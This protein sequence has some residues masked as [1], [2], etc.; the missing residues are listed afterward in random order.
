MSMNKK[1]L[2]F[3]ST[4]LLLLLCSFMVVDADTTLKH[5]YVGENFCAEESVQKVLV[6]AGYILILAKIAVPLILIIVGSLD[7]YKAVMG[8]DEKDLAK[9]LKSLVLRLIAGIFIFFVPTIVNYAFDLIYDSTDGEAVDK[10]CVTCVL[11]PGSC[12]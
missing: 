2:I 11:D 7:L 10:K 6:L 3:I 5:A 4:I 9:S 1:R 8:K 12:K